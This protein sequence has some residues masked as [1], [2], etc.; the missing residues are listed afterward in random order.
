M[1]DVGDR[2]RFIT[3]GDANVESETW[4]AAYDAPV[5]TVR[6]RVPGIGRALLWGASQRTAVVAA[7]L[8]VG[9]VVA[10]GGRRR[11]GRLEPATARGG[12]RL[13]RGGSPGPTVASDR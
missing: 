6:H 8:A 5:P 7:G 3:L 10:L 4:T 11:P 13:A 12:G 1:T 2:V 9:V